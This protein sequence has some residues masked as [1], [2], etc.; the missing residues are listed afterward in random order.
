MYTKF[1]GIPKRKVHVCPA[2]GWFKDFVDPEALLAPTFSGDAILEAGNVNWTQLDVPA[3]TNGMKKASLIV[4]KDERA[5][6]WADINRQIVAQAPGI[7]YI[8][9]KSANIRSRDVQGVSNGYFTTWDLSFTSL[10]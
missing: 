4:D 9:D 2:V 5:K 10:K 6:A 8:W 1:C 7:P 3:I